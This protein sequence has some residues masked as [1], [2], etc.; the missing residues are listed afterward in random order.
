MEHRT[1]RAGAR[2]ALV[3]PLL[4]LS[5]CWVAGVLAHK[6]V[7]EPA[8]P[9]RYKPAAADPMLVLVENAANPSANHVDA[10]RLAA[11]I[12]RDLERYKVAPLVDAAKLDAVRDQDLGGFAV[13]SVA[14]LGRAVGA[15]QVLYVNLESYGIEAA[16]PTGRGRAAAR[17]KVVDVETGQTRWP[18]DQAD[19]YIVTDQTPSTQLNTA[20][21]ARA[22]QTA[23]YDRTAQQIA[24]LFYDYKPN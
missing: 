5:G 14:N 19:G 11:R 21:D 6:V 7:G 20:E 17:V 8:Q 15:K 12:A 13:R 9:A 10:Q 24:R 16:G 23:L 1:A 18:T 3:A 4:L 22:V 2:A